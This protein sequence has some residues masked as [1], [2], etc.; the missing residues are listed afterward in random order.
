MMPSVD[1][2]AIL[3]DKQR[4]D[5]FGCVGYNASTLQPTGMFVAFEGLSYWR[6]VKN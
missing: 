4:A 6:H 2:N 3:T 5:V 1:R